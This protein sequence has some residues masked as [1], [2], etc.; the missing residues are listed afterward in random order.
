[1]GSVKDLTILKAPSDAACGEGYFTFS[2]RY[3]VFDWGEMPDHIP[4][5]GAALNMMSAFNFEKLA[6]AGIPSHFLGISLD[7]AHNEPVSNLMKVRLTK[8]IS[9]ENDYQ[10]YDGSQHHF[11]IPLEIIFRN[12]LPKGSSIF[13]KL[14]RAK[15]DASAI[16]AI[17][18][19]LG[20]TEI[21]QP[22]M[23][24]PEPR[25]DFTT[26][27]ESSDRPLTEAEARRISGLNDAAFEKLLKRAAEVNAFITKQAEAAGFK[28]YDGKIE[29]MYDHGE[30]VLVDVLGTFDE[31]RFL[32]GEEQISKEILRQAYVTLQPEF[33]A[34]T[35]EAKKEA[36]KKGLDEWKPLC[37][38]QPQALPEEFIT[39]VSEI[40]MAGANRYTGKVLFPQ[41]PDLESLIPKLT[42]LKASLKKM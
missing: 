10:N 34:A 28:H 1:M 7:E 17:L 14:E 24:L 35:D 8:V 36:A 13:K 18:K 29:A 39:L 4:N 6:Q 33:V 27:L 22:G 9:P 12:G 40:Y 16:E 25:Y 31:N 37:K 11:L 5:K 38:I 26:K 42:A 21:P 41:A 23:M 19:E 3:S 20:L 2:D 30:I 32:F 15:S